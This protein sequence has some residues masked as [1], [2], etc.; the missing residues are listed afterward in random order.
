MHNFLIKVCKVCILYIAEKN[1]SDKL[2][3]IIKN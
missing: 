3:T 1:D 2:N